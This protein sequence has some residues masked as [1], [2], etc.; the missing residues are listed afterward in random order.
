[1]IS[2]KAKAGSFCR[3]VTRDIDYEKL[4]GG[5]VETGQTVHGIDAYSRHAADSTIPPGYL[6]VILDANGFK[7]IAF[8]SPPDSVEPIFLTTGEWEVAG[9]LQ[10]LDLKRKLM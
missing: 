10:A 5:W 2:L 1:M 8:F 6:D 9:K 4:D 7:H 3:L